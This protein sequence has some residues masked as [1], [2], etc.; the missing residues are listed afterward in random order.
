MIFFLG[1]TISL[2]GRMIKVERSYCFS[3]VR[4]EFKS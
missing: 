1:Q 2:E 4:Y 3:F